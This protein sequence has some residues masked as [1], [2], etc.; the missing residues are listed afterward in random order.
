MQHFLD[1]NSV[2]SNGT[3]FYDKDAFK[4]TPTKMLQ[5][6]EEALGDMGV[7]EDED[8]EYPKKLKRALVITKNKFRFKKSHLKSK[9]RL[10]HME[11]DQMA[12]VYEGDEEVVEVGAA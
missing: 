10:V 7:E 8:E 12:G 3:A 11:G 5:V 9:R 2:V 4:N 1:G 6:A